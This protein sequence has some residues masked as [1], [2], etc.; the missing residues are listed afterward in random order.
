M[1]C[2]EM[3]REAYPNITTESHKLELEV[4]VFQHLEH[5]LTKLDQPICLERGIC[6]HA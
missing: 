4:Y 1:R 2:L 3:V 5:F 6:N